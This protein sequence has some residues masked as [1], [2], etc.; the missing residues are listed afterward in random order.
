M[1]N[2]ILGNFHCFLGFF[3]PFNWVILTTPRSVSCLPVLIETKFGF[4]LSFWGNPV[5]MNSLELIVLSCRVP[6]FL[7]DFDVLCSQSCDGCSYLSLGESWCFHNWFW[8]PVLIWCAGIDSFSDQKFKVNDYYH[9]FIH[10]GKSS[11]Q[12]LDWIGSQMM[13]PQGGWIIYKCCSLRIFS[14]NHPWGLN[15][16]TRAWFNS[17]QANWIGIPTKSTW[18]CLLCIVFIIHFVQRSCYGNSAGVFLDYV[19][20]I[21]QLLLVWYLLCHFK[22]SVGWRCQWTW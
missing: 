12:G 15:R 4:L 18:L 13:Y 3:E 19:N 2:S 7:Q 14:M 5:S 22:R 10:H 21:K 20:A 17:Y 11:R 6:S 1:Y 16:I 9:G 8:W